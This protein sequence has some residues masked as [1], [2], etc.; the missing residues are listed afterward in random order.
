MPLARLFD[1][2]ENVKFKIIN[3]AR[4][5]KPLRFDFAVL[6]RSVCVVLYGIGIQI[7]KTVG[8]YQVNTYLECLTHLLSIPFVFC[9]FHL[10]KRAI[11]K[12]FYLSEIK[13]QFRQIKTIVY[14]HYFYIS[15]CTYLKHL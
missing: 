9:M 3:S 13:Y 7:C 8:K 14:S 12:I 15:H 1:Q 5:F 11:K 4:P 2:N 6:I 10:L